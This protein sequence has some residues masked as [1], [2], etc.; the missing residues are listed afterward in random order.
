MND[1]CCY[2]VHIELCERAKLRTTVLY[3]ETLQ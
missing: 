3:D 2:V 1:L